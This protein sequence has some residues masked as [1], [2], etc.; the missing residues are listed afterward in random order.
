VGSREIVIC[1]YK[2]GISGVGLNHVGPVSYKLNFHKLLLLEVLS[3]LISFPDDFF[4]EVDIR[5]LLGGNDWI[6]RNLLR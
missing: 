5:V 1:L 4:V 3:L 2:C 6:D